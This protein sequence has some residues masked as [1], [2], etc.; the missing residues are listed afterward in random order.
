MQDLSLRIRIDTM[1]DMFLH[2]LQL[3]YW[4]LD[5]EMQLLE[6]NCP[7]RE[8]FYYVYTLSTCCTTAKQH[9]TKQEKPLVTTDQMGFSWIIDVLPDDEGKMEYFL[10]GPFFSMQASEND[11]R[12]MC[13]RLKLSSSL[14]EELL[15]QLKEIPVVHHQAA[16]GYGIMLHSCL[17]G[18]KIRPG[19]ITLCVAPSEK[20]EEADWTSS[21]WH[22]TWSVEQEMFNRIKDGNIEHFQE[23]AAKFGTGRIGTLSDGDPLRQAKNEGIV[24]TTLCSRAAILGGVSPEGGYSL[25]DDYILKIESC[26]SVADV[27]YCNGEMVTAFISR[28][29]HVKQNSCY[30]SVVQACAEY[31]QTHITGKIDLDTMAR[32]QGYNSYYLSRKFQKEMGIS[33]NSYIQLQKVEQAKKMLDTQKLSTTEISERL[34]FSSPS[35]FTSIFRKYTGMT[36]T[37]YLERKD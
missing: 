8:F 5:R 13:Y 31:V 25:A 3:H 37:A 30:S 23:L 36:P 17:T 6:T 21:A 24:F 26:K 34:A 4:H 11:I 20:A 1:Q 32:Q 28:V 29:C 7:N 12:N 35:Y 2:A 14:I 33:L 22:G 15:Q 10:L 27:Q 18:N 9:F 19:D 16:F